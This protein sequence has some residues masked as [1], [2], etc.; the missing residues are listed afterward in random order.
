MCACGE[1]GPL[2][3]DRV[4]H[5]ARSHGARAR[6]DGR[7]ARDPRAAGGDGRRRSPG[8]TWRRRRAA[9]DAD[10]LA[11]L[12]AYA[13]NVALGLAGLANMLDPELIVIAGG[14]VE[15]GPLLFDPLARRVLQP[16][17]GR[18]ATGRRSRSFPPQ[19]GERAGAVGA[20][21]L[22][23]ELLRVTVDASGCT[24]PSFVEDPEIPIAVARAAEAAGLD[25]VFVF[26]HLWRGDPPSRA[27]RARVLRAARRG[28]GGDDAHRASARSS[29]RAT[30]RPAATLANGFATVQR[31]SDGRLI[32][33]IGAG[34]SESRAENEAFG[35]DFGTM[36]DR[37]DALHDAVR[38]ARRRRLPGVGRR[39]RRAGARDRRRSPTAGTV[40]GAPRDRLRALKWRSCARSRPR[41]PSRGAG[42][43]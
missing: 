2:G 29:P 21:V 12:A 7:G 6:R 17:R 1:R 22:A 32:A 10:A 9:G 43:C 5:R 18:R 16:H 41:R 27:A 39:A 24:L 35:L 25:A 28:R 23:R 13:D 42:S 14:L 37:V 19:L 30:L 3:G 31:V 8:V 40:W 34:D 36:V 4:G 15:L 33:G 38:A 26:D 11:L 20:A